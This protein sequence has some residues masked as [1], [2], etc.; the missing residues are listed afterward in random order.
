MKRD[1]TELYLFADDF[2]KAADQYFQHQCLPTNVAHKPTRVP[3]LSTGEIL[4]I[5]L[6]FHQSPCKNFKYFYKGYLLPFYRQEFPHLCSY[7]RF[8]ALKPRILSYLIL[9]LH[10]LYEQSQKTGLWFIDATSLAVCHPKRIRMNKVFRGLAGIG[11]TTKGWFFGLKLHVVINKKGEI[12]GAM[13]TPGNV[14]DRTP[15]PALTK[16][17]KGLLF[18][19]KGYISQTL[20]QNLYQK[21]LKLVTGIKKNMKNKFM[22]IKEKTLLRKRSLIETVFD[23]LKNKF[24]IEHTRH[25]STANAF[26]HILSTL[27]AYSLKTS[28]PKIKFND[29]IQN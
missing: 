6:L 25:R 17:L 4:T 5:V 26:V 29:L 12:Q 1:I 14:D 24:Q 15:V 21:G 3:E 8:V 23:L 13:I 27:V 18:G 20:F 7:Q 10:W 11:K 28:K 19:D 2:C 22:T 16:R 9:L